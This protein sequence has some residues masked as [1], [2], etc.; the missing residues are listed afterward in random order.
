MAEKLAEQILPLV[1]WQTSFD[2]RHNDYAMYGRIR[3]AEPEFNNKKFDE[4][5]RTEKWWEDIL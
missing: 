2:M 3:V 1:E 5:K 4:V